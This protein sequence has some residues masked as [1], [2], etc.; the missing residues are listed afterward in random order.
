MLYLYFY[1]LFSWQFLYLYNYLLWF[2][3]LRRKMKTCMAHFGYNNLLRIFSYL[4]SLQTES[5]VSK[6]HRVFYVFFRNYTLFKSKYLPR[7]HY[8]SLKL[9]KGNTCHFK[10]VFYILPVN[11]NH[12]NLWQDL[13][14]STVQWPSC[15]QEDYYSKFSTSL[16]HLHMDTRT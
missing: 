8:T 2:W 7:K 3:Q 1:I 16:I 6:M 5:C 12:W 11:E 9:F 10:V 14:S 4:I 15:D 13:S